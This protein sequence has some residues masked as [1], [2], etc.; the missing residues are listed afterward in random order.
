MHNALW[1]RQY[2]AYL[3]EFPPFTDRKV[4]RFPY[5]SL[6]TGPRDLPPPCQGGGDLVLVL[7]HVSVVSTTMMDGSLNLWTSKAIPMHRNC[8]SAYIVG[9]LAGGR[10]G[11]RDFDSIRK[12]QKTVAFSVNNRLPSPR[13]TDDDDQRTGNDEKGDRNLSQMN[14]PLVRVHISGV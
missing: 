4:T 10:H 7:R 1:P 14:Q 6:P 9:W 5:A 2:T 8:R 3:H 13:Q 12:R 11:E